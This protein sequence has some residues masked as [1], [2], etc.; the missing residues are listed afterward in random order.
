[1]FGREL[2]QKKGKFLPIRQETTVCYSKTFPSFVRL[3][4]DIRN[5]MAPKNLPAGAGGARQCNA[6]RKA[7]RV[8]L[9]EQSDGVDGRGGDGNA[10]GGIAFRRITIPAFSKSRLHFLQFGLVAAVLA[11]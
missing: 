9:R 7:K 8:A 3:E 2:G 5:P 6:F 4:P 1:M 10:S 11:F